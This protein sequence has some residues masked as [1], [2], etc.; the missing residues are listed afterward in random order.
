M[1]VGY[2]NK[3]S[4]HSIKNTEDINDE[5]QVLDETQVDRVV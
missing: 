4:V 1:F 3:R 5:K 2:Y